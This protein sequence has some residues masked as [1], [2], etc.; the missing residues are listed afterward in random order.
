MSSQGQSTTLTT[1]TGEKYTGIFAGVNVEAS[2]PHYI[3]KM[4]KRLQAA[5]DTANGTATPSDD[6]LGTGDDHLL[7]FSTQ[8][9]VDLAVQNVALDK[10]TAK[11]QNGIIIRRCLLESE[12]ETDI[13]LGSASAFRTDADISGNL[14]VRERNLQRWEP[15]ADNNMDLA[16]DDSGSAGWD[17]FAAN[18]RLYG[19]KTSYDENLYTTSID[20]SDPKYRQIAAKAERL[21]REI[22]GS[23]A[24]NAHV[25]EE[26]GGAMVDDSGFDEEDKYVRTNQLV[27]TID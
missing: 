21:A 10:S 3:L 22:E 17:Q 11:A 9:V 23:S 12:C 14:A 8:D 2:E 13:G 20:K 24:M 16:L 4:T 15:G 18:E 6:Y 1:K 7:T 26:R 5:P 19:I 27:R 25:A